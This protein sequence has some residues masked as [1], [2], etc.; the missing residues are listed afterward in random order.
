MPSSTRRR[1]VRAIG[2]AIA[3]GL[4]GCAGRL[5]TGGGA[6]DTSVDSRPESTSGT[7]SSEGP[8]TLPS[9]VQRGDLPDGR[10]RLVRPGQVSLVNFFTTWCKPCQREM[11]DFRKLRASLDDGTLHLVSVTPEVDE[12]LVREFWREYDATWPVVSDPSLRAT[13]RW[14][15]TS[16]PTNLL[17]DP[18]GDPAGREGPEI[19][20]RTFEEMKRVVESAVGKS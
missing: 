17:F 11:D 19:R 16:Y 12:E 10:V 5:P 6:S 18:S 9:I 8:L 1:A 3:A 7:D 15:A 20:A 4:G 14:D 2:I 13:E